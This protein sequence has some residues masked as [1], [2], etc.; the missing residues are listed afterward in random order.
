[1]NIVIDCSHMISELMPDEMS[2]SLDLSRCKIYVPSIF[3]VECMNAMIMALKRS[4]ITQSQYNNTIEQLIKSPFNIGK[5]SDPIHLREVAKLAR[6]HD[7]TPYDASYLELA[8]R[9][10]A[11]LLTLDKALARAAQNSGIEVVV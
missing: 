8:L 6:H 4:R 11:K 2:A 5:L 10:D 9:M 3:M 1:M 7:L